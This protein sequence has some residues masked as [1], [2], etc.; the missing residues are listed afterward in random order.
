MWHVGLFKAFSDF[1]PFVTLVTDNAYI[2]DIRE[3]EI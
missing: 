2:N 3:K 1:C